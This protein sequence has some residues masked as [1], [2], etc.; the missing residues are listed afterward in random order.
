[1]VATSALVF[2]SSTAIIGFISLLRGATG[3][4]TFDHAMFALSVLIAVVIAFGILRFRVPAKALVVVAGIAA[5]VGV[6]IGIGCIEQPELASQDHFWCG[7][8]LSVLIAAVLLAPFSPSI[9]RQ[10]W[11]WGLRALLLVGALVVA[12][13]DLVGFI[14]PSDDIGNPANDI[15]MINE[16]LAPAAGN[17]PGANFVPQYD[18]LY[19]W[20][21]KPFA[22][23]LSTST[24]VSGAA[25]LLTI[26]MIA[27]IVIGVVIAY[28]TLGRRSIALAILLVVPLTSVSVSH[29]PTSTIAMML[30]ELPIRTFPVMVL[31]LFGIQEVLA[32]SRGR[33]RIVRLALLGIWSALVAWNNHDF[34]VEGVA[35]FAVL[36][37]I[38]SPR[39]VRR[40][41]L[42]A[43]SI[44]L[45]AGLA[46]YPLVLL[47]NGVHLWW[48]SIFFFQLSYASGNGA[49]PIQV[50]GP[51]LVI[52]PLII[53]IAVAGWMTVWRCKKGGLDA[54]PQSV[55]LWRAGLTAAFFGTWSV[56]GFTYYLNRSYAAG[57]LQ[58]YLLSVSVGLTALI[59]IAGHELSARR[60]D[61]GSYLR[62]DRRVLPWVKANGVR[63]ATVAP[64]ALVAML[65]F[66]AI[67]QTENPITTIQ[68]LQTPNYWYHIQ[69]EFPSVAGLEAGRAYADKHG[70]TV[71][72]FGD[73][74]N[75][76]QLASGVQSDNPF[77]VG[78]NDGTATSSVTCNSLKANGAD[79]L[80]VDQPTM[81]LY[82]ASPTNPICGIYRVVHT[83]VAAPFS[84]LER[85][86][87]T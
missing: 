22:G 75:Y 54:D 56:V 64:L 18:S 73:W 33:V 50:P 15:Y 32:L 82:G 25:I 80:L 16:L 12:A 2:A 20:L 66:A 59:V 9:F 10:S 79:I 40:R 48:R 74:G 3:G 37:I 41:A 78:G 21:L 53:L 85:D 60:S 43:W 57:M 55:L 70:K 86:P 27:A 45:V 58:S 28:L 63:L 36:L 69:I 5:T 67:L 84:L 87:A 46:L 30:Q 68:E 6:G 35:V 39:S 19:G 13:S 52:M 62:R 51:V 1:V 7:F 26:F 77:N 71:G 29:D 4:K 42:S 11:H 65:P 49:F 61:A 38:C 47:A 76:M 17:V 72:F 81:S 31:A 34:G 44:A 14:R 83:K 8:G 23:H 24:I